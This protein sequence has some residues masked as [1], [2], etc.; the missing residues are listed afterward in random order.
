MEVSSIDSITPN[1]FCSLLKDGWKNSK[2]SQ[3]GLP[4]E[5]KDEEKGSVPQILSLT[6]ER[7]EMGVLSQVY[8]VHLQYKDDI[9]IATDRPPSDWLL[10]LRRPDLDLSWMFQNES[11]FY[12]NIAPNLV[13]T[14]RQSSFS[15]PFSIPPFLSGDDQHI[16]IQEILD[17]Q[18]IPLMDG[19]PPDKVP[20][21]I[22]CMASLHAKCWNGLSN[23]GQNEKDTLIFP[24]GMGQRL[25]PLQKEG[26]FVKSWQDTI[27]NMD[28][29]ADRDADIVNFIT[30]FCERLETRR[31]RDLHHL[32][33]QHRVTLIHGDFHVSNILFSTKHQD[34]GM[35]SEL[36][37]IDWATTGFANP[38]I[39]LVFFLIVSTSD[40]VVSESPK[41]LMEY[42]RLLLSLE[43]NLKEMLPL[44]TLTVWFKYAL[45]C[46][47]T[48]LVTYDQVCRQ[49]AINERDQ[50]RRELQLQHF[51]NVNRRAI[52]ALRSIDNWEHLWDSLEEATEE[53]KREARNYCEN[54][55]LT[56]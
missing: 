36:Y 24:A 22:H 8:R 26:L 51:R 14:D 50:R 1:L 15:L 38:M 21:L 13:D 11:H 12:R 39:D 2:V 28:F 20:L 10:K 19:C 34:K 45:V 49:I 33:H 55:T 17:V 42:H 23:I 25:H 56:I 40:Q 43:P 32:V 18:T 6:P 47:W 27:D 16:I 44:G 5:G 4:D 41:H 53:E 9:S 7:V 31:I 29:H 30:E 35:G 52:L 37:V 54:T 48:I 3:Y 46:Q